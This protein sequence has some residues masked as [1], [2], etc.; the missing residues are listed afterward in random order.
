VIFLY[1]HQRQFFYSSKPTRSSQFD[2]VMLLMASLMTSKIF[3]HRNL[4]SATNLNQFSISVTFQIS[5][6]YEVGKENVSQKGCK[7]NK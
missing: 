2:D 3:L 7:I 5:N 4:F 6:F 1:L